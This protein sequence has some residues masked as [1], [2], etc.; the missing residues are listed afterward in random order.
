MNFFGEV[1]QNLG[2]IYFDDI[3]NSEFLSNAKWAWKLK[4]VKIKL[5]KYIV[6]WIP[7]ILGNIKVK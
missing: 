3:Y 6:N 7:G 1:M 2:E 4:S 5:Y